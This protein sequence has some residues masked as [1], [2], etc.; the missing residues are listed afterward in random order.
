L[1]PEEAFPLGLSAL[2]RWRS[3]PAKGQPDATLPWATEP[4]PDTPAAAI[5]AY[6]AAEANA[7]GS[8]T[9]P[10]KRSSLSWRRSAEENQS[11]QAGKEAVSDGEDSWRVK[12]GKLEVSEE[13]WVARQTARRR[14][15]S[16]I[17]E[18]DAMSDEDVVRAMKSIL[19][20]LTVEKFESLSV[21]LIRCGIRNAF[22]VELLIQEVF[23]KATTQHHFI[24]MYADLCDLLNIHFAEHP[25]GG[26]DDPKRNFKK[27]LLHCCQASFE[28]HLTPPKGLAELNS[29]DRL[30]AERQYKMR[31][32]GNIKFVGAL[33][34]RKML[35]S[36]VM[37]AIMEELLQDPTPEALESLASLLTVVGPTFDTP[38]WAYRV[39]LN[40]I[41]SQVEKITKKASIDSRVRCLLKDVVDI[42][43]AGWQDRRPKKIEGPLKL[44]QVAAKAAMETNWVSPKASCGGN[45]WDTVGKER[46]GKL[47]TLLNANSKPTSP[48]TSPTYASTKQQPAIPQKEKTTRGGCAGAMM[49]EFLRN[50]DK[51]EEKVEKKFDQ[52]ACKAEIS[53]TLAELRVSHDVPEAIIRVSGIAVPVSEQPKQLNDLL[54]HLAEEGTA[55]AR[56]AGF[57]LVAGLILEGHWKAESAE[58]GIHNFAE[59]TVPDLMFDVPALPQILREEL[60]PAFAPVV[61][62]GLLE[63]DLLS[64]FMKV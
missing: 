14:T 59:D 3:S 4:E 22:H 30:V 6:A 10:N 35:A 56:K 25:V 46:L 60:H 47:C 36:K 8:T 40:A 26:L 51:P 23:E 62:A 57:G 29:E 5:A 41:F 32:I 52:D 42:R 33:L 1:E 64:V 18:A 2:L 55:G 44:E 27:I 12:P 7:T 9:P 28:K 24:D 63:A 13:S 50:R 49:L 15:K 34:V 11:R 58:K 48:C 53:A 21:Q 45:D 43:N 16:N 19:N 37:L 31:M 38:D 17:T 39:T 54:V 61:D 20:K